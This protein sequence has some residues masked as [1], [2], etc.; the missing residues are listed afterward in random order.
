MKKFFL[1][2]K[3]EDIFHKHLTISLLILKKS[4]QLAYCDIV[5]VNNSELK[6]LD[7]DLKK[8]LKAYR[9]VENMELRLLFSN[10][11]GN[12]NSNSNFYFFFSQ[13]AQDDAIRY[14]NNK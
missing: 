11:N 8:T 6:E 2:Y 3:F 9:E 1:F 14:K 4:R 10:Y 13:I 7:Y 5:H 12:N